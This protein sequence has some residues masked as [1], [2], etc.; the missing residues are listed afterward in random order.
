MAQ[1]AAVNF[2]ESGKRSKI[3]QIGGQRPS[4]YPRIDDHLPTDRE[5]IHQ[6]ICTGLS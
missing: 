1:W 5:V 3:S 4:N 2:L 6:I